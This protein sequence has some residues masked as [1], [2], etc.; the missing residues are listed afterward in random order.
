[1]I[2]TTVEVPG[3]LTFLN[4]HAD[5]DRD[6]ARIS[7]TRSLVFL[8]HGALRCHCAAWQLHTRAEQLT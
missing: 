5:I 3:Q 7:P 4:V 2:V 8:V 6:V 1:M